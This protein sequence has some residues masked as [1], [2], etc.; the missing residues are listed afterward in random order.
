MVSLG[1]P[2]YRRPETLARAL[3]SVLAQT[4]RD[5]EV[6]VS[7]DEPDDDETE[8]VVRDLALADPRVRYIRQ[9]H[10][11]GHARNYSFVLGAASGEHFMWL[12]DD[13][14]IDPA[15]VERCLDAL[16]RDDSL[17]LVAGL[18]RYYRD[19]EHVI[20]ERP[21]NLLEERAAA[22]VVR[23]FAR[24]N[25]NGALFGIARRE[26]L[27]QVGFP[28][29]VGGDWL[30]VAALAARGGVRTLSDVHVHRSMSGLGGDARAL[31][32]SFGHT[33]LAARSH[34]VLVARR[35]AADIGWRDPAYAAMSR[36]ER[37]VAAAASAALIVIRFPGLSL[38]RRILSALGLAHLEDRAAA[39]VRAREA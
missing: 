18:A 36:P 38:V 16:A 39:W 28:D 11:L 31:A 9:P 2:T 27:L 4:H 20:D 3:R 17:R 1:I 29:V 25:M 30:L 7:D 5:L 19:G 32:E 13:D 23:Y 15:Y 24:V 34:Q 21:I 37:L 22:R 26:D 33:G 35:L 10:N 14:W 6:I 8:R 12:A